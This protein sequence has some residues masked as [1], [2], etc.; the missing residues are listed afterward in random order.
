MI[1]GKFSIYATVRFTL[2]L[3]V[4]SVFPVFLEILTVLLGIIKPEAIPVLVIPRAKYVVAFF[5]HN[6]LQSNQRVELTV[7]NASHSFVCMFRA[8]FQSSE[9][10]P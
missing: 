5:S 8:S 6:D 10:H 1:G 2:L 7:S 4:Y 9:A 3:R